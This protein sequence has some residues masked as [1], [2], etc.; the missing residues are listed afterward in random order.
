MSDFNNDLVLRKQCVVWPQHTGRVNL[1]KHIR[2]VNRLNSHNLIHIYIYIISLWIG[3]HREIATTCNNYLAKS[4]TIVNHQPVTVKLSWFLFSPA[5][6]HVACEFQVESHESLPMS[7]WSKVEQGISHQFPLARH[8][9]HH[10][11]SIIALNGCFTICSTVGLNQSWTV[12]KLNIHLYSNKNSGYV[13]IC[14]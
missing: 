6:T 7:Q 14:S 8:K 4:W 13:S 3:R 1:A 10:Y 9:H 5:R 2:R 12:V 11:S